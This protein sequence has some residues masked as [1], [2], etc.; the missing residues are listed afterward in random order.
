MVDSLCHSPFSF[1]ACSFD[2]S[3]C[4][5]HEIFSSEASEGRAL[6]LQ[7]KLAELALVD[8]PHHPGRFRASFSNKQRY[9]DANG[10]SFVVIFNSMACMAI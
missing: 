7:T 3:E 4:F 6:Q 8:P 2:F 9:Y 10:S 5:E 1:E